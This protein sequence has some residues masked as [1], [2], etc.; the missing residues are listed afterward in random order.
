MRRAM[1]RAMID[2]NATIYALTLRFRPLNISYTVI[3][4]NATVISRQRIYDRRALPRYLVLTPPSTSLRN[5]NRIFSRATII[6]VTMRKAISKLE[7]S[8]E[9]GSLASVYVYLIY[10]MKRK[11]DGN[12]FSHSPSYLRKFHRPMKQK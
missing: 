6:S 4:S 2:K 10:L 1:R 11:D 12:S 5:A 9:L 8:R 7:M 3:S